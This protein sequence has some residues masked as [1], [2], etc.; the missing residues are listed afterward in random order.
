MIAVDSSVWIDFFDHPASR[1]AQALGH[2]IELDADLGIVDISLT[3]ILCGIKEDRVFRDIQERLRCFS[4]L[5]VKGEETFIHAAQIA[6]TCA[7]HGKIVSKP[8][9]LYIAAVT[10]EQGAQLFHK[11]KDFDVMADHVPLRIYSLPESR[12]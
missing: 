2:L 11:D 3:E 7:R 6:R 10:M 1:Y 4:V 9:D 12:K 5:P 8:V